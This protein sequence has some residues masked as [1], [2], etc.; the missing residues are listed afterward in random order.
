MGID[1]FVK[2]I[3]FSGAKAI[4]V[5]GNDVYSRNENYST[6]MWEN[7]LSQLLNFLNLWRNGKVY[8]S[9]VYICGNINEHISLEN[10]VATKLSGSS[11]SYVSA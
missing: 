9:D 2:W 7:G 8:P 3:I 11:S 6:V 4:T 1:K 5:V 10:G